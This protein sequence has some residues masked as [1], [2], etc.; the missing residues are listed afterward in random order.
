MRA[1]TIDLG[2]SHATLALVE[3]SEVVCCKKLSLH[4]EESLGAILPLF[5]NTFREMLVRHDSEIDT[6]DGLVFGFCGLA[7]VRAGRVLS[8]NKKYDDAP[9]LDLPGWCK[10][11]FGIRFLI[12]NDARM[13][14]LGEVNAGAAK[15]FEDIVMMTLGTGIGGAAMIDGQL[16]RGKHA[17]AGCLGGHLPARFDGRTCTCGAVGCVE[18]EASSWALPALVAEWP[19]FSG[20]TLASSGELNFR[21]LFQSADGGDPVAV[22]VRDHCV[23][24]WSS[25]VVGLIHAYD[26][27]VV[28]IGGGV[29]R[30]SRSILPAIE[31]YVHQHAWTPWGKVQVVQAALGDHAALL[32]AVPLLREMD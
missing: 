8:T 29:M 3:D 31:A 32:G 18:T 4:Q 16:L 24:V 13:A 15:G 7:D 25:A 6:W 23:S 20:S 26:P 22:A 21:T 17:Q 12:E 10:R 11:E 19:G 14:L 28:V 1:L 27:E 9:L 5:A 30:S 2:G